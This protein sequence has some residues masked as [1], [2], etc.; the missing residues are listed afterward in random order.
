MRSLGSIFLERVK[1][2]RNLVDIWRVLSKKMLGRGLVPP[3]N[4]TYGIKRRLPLRLYFS[5]GS[6]E[7]SD[8][9]K[10]T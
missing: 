6:T 8:Q 4:C 3:S 1:Y 2:K 5:K 10:L 9:L 7:F